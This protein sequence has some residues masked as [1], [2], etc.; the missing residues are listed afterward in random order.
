MQAL[1][2]RQPYAELILR[3]IKRIEFRSRPTRR[4]GER[5]YIYASKGKVG[6]FSEVRQ[7][8]SEVRKDGANSLPS[9][10]CLPP[11]TPWSEDL[12]VA[13][14]PGWLVELW[15]QVR[16]IEAEGHDDWPRGVIVGSAVIEKVEEVASYQLPVGSGKR[17]TPHPNPFPEYMA[18]ENSDARHLLTTS[19]Q[20]LATSS[21][22]MYAWHLTDVQ[23]ARKLRKPSGRPQPV[24][25][26]PF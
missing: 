13:D 4:I 24:W 16:M 3:G 21:P 9:A 10:Y 8:R 2:I 19:N 1:S 17:K 22:P 14:A 15:E 6:S 18:R 12:R 23:R 25:F 11:T 7:Q 5:F 20:Q 26:S